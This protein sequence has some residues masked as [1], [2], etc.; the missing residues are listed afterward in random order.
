[1][2]YTHVGLLLE[3]SAGYQRA[4]QA[5]VEAFSSSAALMALPWYTHYNLCTSLL[6]HAQ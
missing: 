1:M 5:S 3:V 2:C 6:S 4:C